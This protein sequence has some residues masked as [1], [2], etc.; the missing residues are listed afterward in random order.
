MALPSMRSLICLLVMTISLPL[1][2]WAD[3][4]AYWRFEDH[5]PGQKL[6]AELGTTAEP[7]TVTQDYSGNGNPL[8]T[9]NT[10]PGIYPPDTSATFHETRRLPKKLGDQENHRKVRF[11]GRQDFFTH[12]DVQPPIESASLE[13]FTIEGF[14]LLEGTSRQL[15]DQY[16]VIVGKDGRPVRRLGFQPLA[17]VVAGKDDKYLKRDCLSINIIDRSGQYRVATS[18]KPLRPDQ[19]YAFAAVCDAQSLKLYI[20]RFDGNG[21]Q[22]EAQT[23]VD[24]G[25]IQSSGQWAVGRGMYNNEPNSWFYGSIDEIRISD[26]ALEPSDWLAH[27]INEIPPLPQPAVE[28]VKPVFVASNVA[29]PSV[30]YHEGVYYLYG[31]TGISSFTVWTSTDLVNWEKGP[32]VLSAGEGVWGEHAFWA[33]SIIE[34]RGKFYLFYSANGPLPEV[35]GKRAVRI[36]V[37]VA[38]SPLGPFKE[39]VARM[40]LMGRAVIDPCPF[41]DDDGQAY[42]YFVSDLP[43]NNGRGQIYVIRLSDDLLSPI[44]EAVMCIEPSQLWEGTVWNEGPFVF[45]VEDTYVMMYSG[46]FWAS[47]DYAVGVATAPT[48]F[49]PWNKRDDNPFLRRYGGLMG[50]GHNSLVLAPDGKTWLN[51]FHAHPSPTRTQPRETW[52]TAIEIERDVRGDIRLRA[53]PWEGATD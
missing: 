13:T 16:R 48:P 6:D 35:P 2:A 4:L 31:T 15:G 11:V 17:V 51:F 39:V 26:T 33:P 40:P 22:L 12:S 1:G 52:F 20:N 43:D 41:I 8:R 10:R 42:L 7:F 24:G 46:S 25:L 44:G 28:T 53:V 18:S 23:E 32:V 29:D 19:W 50:T 27:G 38:D 14:F 30:L 37:A 21:Y 3:V 34:H 5:P 36:S 49:G 9:W 47:H 45:R